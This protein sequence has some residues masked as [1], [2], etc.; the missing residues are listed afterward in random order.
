MK[1]IT[2]ERLLLRELTPDDAPRFWELQRDP[3][4]SAYTGDGGVHPLEEVERLLRDV[5]CADYR[6]HGYGRWAVVLRSDSQLIGFAGLKYL[7]ERDEVD[8]GYR[9]GPDY[10]GQ[11]LASEACRAAMDYAWREL[12]LDRVVAMVIHK[13]VASIRV[14]EKLGFN[15]QGDEVDD[16]IK[17]ALY[18]AER[19]AAQG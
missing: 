16:G 2:T 14:L 11:G 13:N 15:Y 4:M 10:W 18:A 17:V 1:T 12:E 6:E 5:V 3:R 7:P 8:L 19:P 9:L